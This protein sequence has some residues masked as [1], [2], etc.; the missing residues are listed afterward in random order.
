MPSKQQTKKDP[1]NGRVGQRGCGASG[2]SASAVRVF[3]HHVNDGRYLLQP[4]FDPVWGEV[5]FGSEL[6]QKIGVDNPMLQ[7]LYYSCVL[8]SQTPSFKRDLKRLIAKVAAAIRSFFQPC[9][10]DH[11]HSASDNAAKGKQ[12]IDGGGIKGHGG[13]PHMRLDADI[14]IERRSPLAMEN[15]RQADVVW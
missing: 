7:W 6:A 3:G 9:C 15:A 13:T 12:P 8:Q 2:L 10:D 4:E 5:I 11:R 1:L 14:V